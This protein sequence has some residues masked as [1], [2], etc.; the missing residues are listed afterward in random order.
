MFV[1]LADREAE[2]IAGRG[3]ERIEHECAHRLDK[4]PAPPGAFDGQAQQQVAEVRVAAWRVV[5]TCTGERV[6]PCPYEGSLVDIAMRVCAVHPEQRIWVAQAHPVQ[7]GLTHAAVVGEARHAGGAADRLIKIE[8]A[9]LGQ[10]QH[11]GGRERLGDRVGVERGRRRH[12]CSVSRV[13]QAV[14]QL[15]QGYAVADDEV[16][17]TGRAS[18]LQQRHQPLP[19]VCH[20]RAGQAGSPIICTP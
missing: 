9:G 6:H 20:R 13:R 16:L 19:H 12:G 1:R 5:P 14:V 18:L 17:R 15:E 4:R 10:R 3:T 11:C 8:R 7:H 2:V